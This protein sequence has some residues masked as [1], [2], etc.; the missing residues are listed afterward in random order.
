MNAVLDASQDS[1]EEDVQKWIEAALDF[2]CQYQRLGLRLRQLREINAALSEFCPASQVLLDS[3]P[4][5]TAL[6]QFSKNV[7][8]ERAHE[9]ARIGLPDKPLL[10]TGKQPLERS[11]AI[12]LAKMDMDLAKRIEQRLHDESAQPTSAESPRPRQLAAK[13]MATTFKL[14]NS[15]IESRPAVTEELLRNSLEP[16]LSKLTEIEAMLK[17]ARN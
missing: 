8:D 10:S 12:V 9:L 14:K 5:M 11:K 3:E 6:I 7:D 4:P 2:S 13:I 17:K 1:A 16:L 15:N